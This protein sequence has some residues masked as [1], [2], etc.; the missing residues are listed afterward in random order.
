MKEFDQQAY[1]AMLK[2]LQQGDLSVQQISDRFGITERTAYRWLTYAKKDG[3]D[4][5]RRG[6]NPTTYQA[7]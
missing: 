7:V 6:R 3:W 2:E 5:V 1:E 4:I